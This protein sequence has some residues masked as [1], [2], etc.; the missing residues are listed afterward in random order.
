MPSSASCSPT[1]GRSRSPARPSS[2][3]CA[4]RAATATTTSPT[5][6]TRG[7]AILSFPA[8]TTRCPSVKV[9]TT[10][11]WSRPSTP[12]RPWPPS[13]AAVSVSYPSSASRAAV[14]RPPSRSGST[15]CSR[16]TT[17]SCARRAVTTHRL[18]YP[19]RSGTSTTTPT[20]P[21]SRRAS[22]PPAR[23]TTCRR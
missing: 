6:S 1:H 19:C 18:A 10:S 20:W 3:P 14:A 16:T 11:M 23:W 8:T 2:L 4:P 17:A 9:P 22:P 15:S 5:C 13:T 7:C 21:S 12:C